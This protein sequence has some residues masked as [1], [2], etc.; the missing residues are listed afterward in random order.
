[1]ASRKVLV[2][3]LL[4]AI[5]SALASFTACSETGGPASPQAPVIG[6]DRDLDASR[7][8][9]AEANG[10][11]PR[12]ASSAAGNDGGSPPR[13]PGPPA[14]RF[15]GRFDTR[16]PAGP[17]CGWP[18]CRIIAR[19]SGTGVKARLDER[20]EPWMQGGPSEWDV[21]VDGVLSP[22]LVLELGPHDYELASGLTEGPHVV[23]LYKRSETQNGYTQFLGYD[24]GDGTLL[25]PPLPPLRRI[26]MIGDSAVAGFGIEGVGL[27]ADCPGPDWGATWQNFHKSVGARLGEIFDADLN[28]TVYSGKGL[29]RNI[30]RP[31]P[32][33]MPVVYPRAN[34][35]DKTSVYDFTRFVPDVIVI[36]L[37]GNDF[38]IGQGYDDGPTPLPDFTRATHDFVGTLRSHAPVAHIFLALSPS[39]SDD[40]PPGH[41]SRTSVK[42]AF[43]AV[44]AQASAAGDRRVYSVAPPAAD[45]SEL[46]ACNGHGTP[47]Y[48]DRVAQQLAVMIRA[49]TGW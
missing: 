33:T 39:V 2:R 10:N 47:A 42:A 14:V 8:D 38:A 34:P 45:P 28:G 9:P 48:H 1:M 25:P 35:V 22:K 49:R 7:D 6:M 27:G 29:V 41:Q 17:T 12:P 11:G 40:N 31:D 3:A 26:E 19:F 20:V 21:V 32:D 23:E 5:A 18:G 30:Y 4:V 43:D 16:D 46:T 36:M 37:G 13:D 15:V 44:A 24:Y